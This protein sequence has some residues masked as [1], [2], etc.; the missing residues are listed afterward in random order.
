MSLEKFK[1]FLPRFLSEES[2]KELFHGLNDFPNNIADRMYTSYLKEK[3]VVF[4][5]DGLKDMMV[6]NLP[7]TKVDKANAVILSNS[8]DIDLDNP[9]D[10]PARACYCPIFNLEKYKALLIKSS[11]KSTQQ[12]ESHIEDIKK[13]KV[14]QIFYLPKYGETLDESLVFLDRINNINNTSIDRESLK[15]KRIFTLSNLGFYLFLFKLSVHLMRI[16]EGVDRK[17]D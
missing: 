12:V 8:C 2:K 10:I 7:E 14:T 16:R 9:R 13:Q 15:D 6:V 1:N 4:Q 3:S 11:G 17:T 5:G